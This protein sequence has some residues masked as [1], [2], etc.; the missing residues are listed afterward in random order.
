MIARDQNT[1][2]FG[3]QDSP[4]RETTTQP[5]RQGN[6]IRHHVELF[7][8]EQATGP[9]NTSLNFIKNQQD[10][11]GITETSQTPNV[12]HICR[13]HPTL[14]LH[15]FHHNRRG[16]VRDGIFDGTEIVE[17]YLR[18]TVRHRRKW[19]LIRNRA[20]RSRCGECSTMKRMVRRY[21]LVSTCPIRFPPLTSN[22]DARLS[23][24]PTAVHKEHSVKIR[25]FDQTLGY[26]KLRHRIEKI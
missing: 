14:T 13:P 7:I 1:C 4:N 12:V 10:A 17:R 19:F 15:R 8:C 11:L 23:S 22:L 5:L 26:F 3:A 2:S 21:D 6:H 25:V 18:E 16:F 9:P 24:F 20:G